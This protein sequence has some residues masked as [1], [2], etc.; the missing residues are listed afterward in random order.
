MARH[1]RRW[2]QRFCNLF[3]VCNRLRI[4]RPLGVGVLAMHGDQLHQLLPY[5]AT[6]S[7]WKFSYSRRA[8][9]I[10][11]LGTRRIGYSA[12]AIQKL[13]KSGAVRLS[14]FK[15]NCCVFVNLLPVI[16]IRD[17]LRPFRRNKLAPRRLARARR[18]AVS[19]WHQSQ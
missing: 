15:S 2:L 17:T 9:I 4:H 10:E 18:N 1:R 5:W 19:L 14:Q 7:F 13:G 6:L 3:Q 11:N 8:K 12:C 16:S